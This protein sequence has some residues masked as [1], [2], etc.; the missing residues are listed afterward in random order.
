[1]EAHVELAGPAQARCRKRIHLHQEFSIHPL[2]VQSCILAL[3]LLLSKSIP[4][5]VRD[6]TPA[7]VVIERTR[8]LGGG[9]GDSVKLGLVERGEHPP[10]PPLLAG[11]VLDRALDVT[12]GAEHLVPPR[13]LLCRTLKPEHLQ[14]LWEEKEGR[15]R[16]VPAVACSRSLSTLELDG[17]P[18]LVSM[19]GPDDP[20]LSVK[21]A[22]Y[23]QAMQPHALAQQVR[24][25]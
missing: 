19:V 25:K 13:R 14:V 17:V 8:M 6:L 3:L 20:D 18:L 1:M 2:T 24:G 7:R 15:A 10:Q 4:Q 21:L 22:A 16:G 5:V 9:E 11:L 12:L 23:T